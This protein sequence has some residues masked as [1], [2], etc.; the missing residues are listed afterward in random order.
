MA[1][2]NKKI[3]TREFLASVL[4]KI[5]GKIGLRLEK[6]DAWR[7]YYKEITADMITG[8]MLLNK[9]VEDGKY[10]YNANFPSSSSNEWKSLELPKNMKFKMPTGEVERFT[11]FPFMLEVYSLKDPNTDRRTVQVM[12]IGN[13]GDKKVYYRYTQNINKTEEAGWLWSEWKSGFGGTSEVICINGKN[14]DTELKGNVTFFSVPGYSEDFTTIGKGQAVLGTLPDEANGI[15]DIPNYPQQTQQGQFIAK[16]GVINGYQIEDKYQVIQVIYINGKSFIRSRWLKHEY[17]NGDMQDGS[18]GYTQNGSKNRIKI[19]MTDWTIWQAQ[20]TK[21]IDKLSDISGELSSVPSIKMFTNN[22][23]LITKL[24]SDSL[25]IN[26]QD[27]YGNFTGYNKFPLSY[28]SKNGIYWAGNK[29]Y[30]CIKD[31]SGATISAPNENFEEFSLAKIFD[32]VNTTIRII[33][34]AYYIGDIAI[35]F[36]GSTYTGSNTRIVNTKVNFKNINFIGITSFISKGQT[37]TDDM[38]QVLYSSYSEVVNS[39]KI[40]FYTKGRQSIDILV[41]GNI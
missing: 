34:R 4:K 29:F 12:Y 16:S 20:P 3:I 28:A 1:D 17:I 22:N 40:T 15:Y 31:Y 25:Y 21:M 27:E 2:E 41:I 35:E 8:D 13:Y 19:A 39:H 5:V 7:N 32:K 11:D 14:I 9:I 18:G 38:I 33:G 37:N 23:N 10:I 36:I 24:F 26:Q 30:I 6:K